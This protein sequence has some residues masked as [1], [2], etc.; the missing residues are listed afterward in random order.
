MVQVARRKTHLSGF[1][2]QKG[3]DEC[4]VKCIVVYIINMFQCYI[5][6]SVICQDTS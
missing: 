5:C 2:S 3:G 1:S 4:K 6:F